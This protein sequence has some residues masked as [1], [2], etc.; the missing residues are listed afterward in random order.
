M[1]APIV[2]FDK[3]GT[4]ESVRNRASVTY[5]ATADV[6][7]EIIL[8]GIVAIAECATFDSCSNGGAVTFEATG[9]NH[10]AATL[11]GL[12][13]LVDNQNGKSE[14]LSCV[15]RGKITLNAKCG[16]PLNDF[17]YGGSGNG[18]GNNLGGICGTSSWG[19]EITMFDQCNNETAGTISLY[20]SD[21]SGLAT[22]TSS[23]G[24]VGVAGILG[25]GQGEFNK[26]RNYALISVKSLVTGEPSES[27]LKRR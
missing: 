22:S 14:F 26:C 9:Y 10:K 16:D 20:H 8:G 27:S 6:E 12:V 19:D 1:F 2:K 3:G 5:T 24:T 4:Y 18:R 17:T 7:Q 23:S 25:M 13:G 21:I 15:N 11:G